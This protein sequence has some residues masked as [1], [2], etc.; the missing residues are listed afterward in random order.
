[1]GRREASSRPGELHRTYADLGRIDFDE[2]TIDWVLP[3]GE[4]IRVLRANGFEVED[5]IELRPRRDAPTTYDDSRRRSGRAAGPP[6][7]SGRRA[8]LGRQRR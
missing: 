5:L 1:M 6:S 2:G 7:G 3:P 4:W 8:A